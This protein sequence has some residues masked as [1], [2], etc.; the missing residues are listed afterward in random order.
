MKGRVIVGL[1]SRIRP[2][3]A[4]ATDQLMQKFAAAA[5]RA[6]REKFWQRVQAARQ[7][8]NRR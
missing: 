6:R 8:E 5:D 2:V 4:E 1:A 7:Q 3:P